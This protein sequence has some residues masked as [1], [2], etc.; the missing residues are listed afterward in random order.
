MKET[1]DMV[2]LN[3]MRMRMLPRL[4]V[5]PTSGVLD[6]LQKPRRVQYEL[7]DFEDDLRESCMR[8]YF[9]CSKMAQF[10]QRDIGTVPTPSN[11]SKVGGRAHNCSIEQRS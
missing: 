4:V 7:L 6:A 3:D 11:L 1:F 9:A 10:L 5:M 2:A 8:N